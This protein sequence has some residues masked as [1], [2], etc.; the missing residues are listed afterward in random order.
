M[1]TNQIEGFPQEIIDKMMERQVKQ[2]YEYYKH[3]K[4]C[5]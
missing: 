2:I 4:E 3:Q 1:N 5:S